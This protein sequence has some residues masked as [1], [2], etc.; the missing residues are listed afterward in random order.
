MFAVALSFRQISVLRMLQE[1]FG[2][3]CRP[4]PK[5]KMQEGAKQRWRHQRERERERFQ[6]WENKKVKHCLAQLACVA[7]VL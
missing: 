1:P 7:Q 6:N 3:V 2:T 4:R 5:A